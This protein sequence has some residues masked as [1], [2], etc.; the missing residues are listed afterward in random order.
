MG[1]EDIMNDEEGIQP[2]DCLYLLIRFCNS[3]KCLRT[4]GLLD[5]IGNDADAVSALNPSDCSMIKELLFEE[6]EPSIF[7]EDLVIC[8]NALSHFFDYCTENDIWLSPHLP[9]FKNDQMLRLLST[10]SGPSDFDKNRDQVCI[11]LIGYCFT[12]ITAK[13][14]AKKDPHSR[15][16]L[17]DYNSSLTLVDR[18]IN[19]PMS[20]IN[21]IRHAIEHSNYELYEGRIILNNIKAGNRLVVEPPQFIS[22]SIRII[23]EI[24]EEGHYDGDTTLFLTDLVGDIENLSNGD[25]PCSWMAKISASMMRF[26][27]AVSTH[28]HSYRAITRCASD[29]GFNFEYFEKNLFNA[30][31][32]NPCDVRNSF[33][34]ADFDICGDA[35]ICHCESKD[36]DRYD[37][38]CNIQDILEMSNKAQIMFKMPEVLWAIAMLQS[39]ANNTSPHSDSE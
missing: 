27:S 34:H 37:L 39:F 20:L 6:L 35:V 33:A 36:K 17:S 3:T 21:D 4:S 1:T 14:S 15:L 23:K 30:N 28:S 18:T 7:K 19:K 32:F 10:S 31:G 26:I 16:N 13:K 24:I 29:L 38:V 5:K 8:D 12:V 22:D 11:L 2:A 25:R 9:S